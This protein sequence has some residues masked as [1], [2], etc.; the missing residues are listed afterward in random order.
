[1]KIKHCET[2]ANFEVTESK[3]W[4]KS[5]YFEKVKIIEKGFYSEKCMGYEA[6]FLFLSILGIFEGSP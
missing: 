1:M 6:T 5:Q 4:E 3:L 2:V